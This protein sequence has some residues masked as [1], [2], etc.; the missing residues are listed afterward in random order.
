MG[1]EP[2]QDCRMRIDHDPLSAAVIGAAIEVHRNLGPGLF[3]SAYEECLAWELAARGMPVCRQVAIPVV[4]KGIPLDVSYH[5][6]LMVGDTHLVEVK[7]VDSLA[8]V[9]DAEVLTYLKM[10]G[11][12]V[13]LLLNFN[14]PVLKDGIRRFSARREGETT[15]ASADGGRATAG[16]GGTPPPRHRDA[17]NSPEG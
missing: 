12:R 1:G 13:G 5:V 8:S 9:H 14:T 6:D 17:K 2:E 7:A 4:Y 15:A 3:E 16:D 10:S 11:A